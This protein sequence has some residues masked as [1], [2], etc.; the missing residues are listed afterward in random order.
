[1]RATT[2]HTVLAREDMPLSP[3]EREI[4]ALVAK[5]LSNQQIADALGL[6]LATIKANMSMIFAKLHVN[7]RVGLTLAVLETRDA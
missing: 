5:G 2:R 3:R 6:K 1:M 4:A 7:N